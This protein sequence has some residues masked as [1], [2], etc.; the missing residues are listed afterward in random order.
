M[1]LF[2]CVVKESLAVS[3]ECPISLLQRNLLG[4]KGLSLITY[5]F[6]LLY[7]FWGSEPPP[8]VEAVLC[9]ALSD[10]RELFKVGAGL[11]PTVL[12]ALIFIFSSRTKI[13]TDVAI[14]FLFLKD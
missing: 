11:N 8:N 5:C 6:I 1:L 7:F 3:V 2:Y 12:L 9:H 10:Y 14:V 13:E 4:F